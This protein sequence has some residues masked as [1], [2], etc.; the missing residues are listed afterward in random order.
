MI[1]IATSTEKKAVI[2]TKKRYSASTLAAYV[3]PCSGKNG[4]YDSIAVRNWSA[5][6]ER[7]RDVLLLLHAAAVA[8]SRRHMTVQ[9]ASIATIVAM[10][11]ACTRRI[12]SSP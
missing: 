9:N 7:R 11:P 1:S 10:P 2:A 8:R 4:R 12:V 3:E 5:P 6:V